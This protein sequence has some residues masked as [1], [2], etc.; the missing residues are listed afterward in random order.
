MQ[1]LSDLVAEPAWAPVGGTGT[2]VGVFAREV[3]LQRRCFLK[4]VVFAKLVCLHIVKGL[5]TVMVLLNRFKRLLGKLEQ[6]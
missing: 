6:G 3:F 1:F 5:D 4:G 2:R